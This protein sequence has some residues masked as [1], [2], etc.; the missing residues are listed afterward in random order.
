VRCLQF[1]F[2][3][4]TGV[5]LKVSEYGKPLPVTFNFALRTLSAWSTLRRSHEPASLGSSAV[6]TSAVS[7]SAA[8]TSA[9]DAAAARAFRRVF[10][11]GDN[12]R[13]DVRGANNAGPLWKSILVE[14]GV[15][16]G[17]RAGLANDATDPAAHVCRD[18][19]EAVDV[20]VTAAGR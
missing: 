7:T 11:V 12:P 5:E 19:S 15:F 18:V 3:E 8:G 13:A 1:L 4:A 16:E 2:K 17:R 20:I 10:M 14:T 6:S 9:A